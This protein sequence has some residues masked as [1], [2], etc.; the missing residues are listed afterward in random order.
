MA[1]PCMASRGTLAAPTRFERATC[2]LGGFGSKLKSVAT[3]ITYETD[4]RAVATYCVNAVNLVTPA[5]FERATC[6][7]GGDRSIQLSYGARSRSV[8]RREAL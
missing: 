4:S 8:Y 6:R 5:R 2:P 7:L 3:S 1:A